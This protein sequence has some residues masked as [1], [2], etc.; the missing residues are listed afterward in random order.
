MSLIPK[1]TDPTLLTKA[2]K[3]NT[4]TSRHTYLKRKRKIG[5]GKTE[6]AGSNEQCIF[7]D[8]LNKC[9]LLSCN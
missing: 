2:D 1:E 8:R 4:P 3:F 9:W 7:K 5:D 6:L